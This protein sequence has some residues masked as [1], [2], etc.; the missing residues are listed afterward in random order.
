MKIKIITP[1]NIELEYSLANLGSR[2]AAFI[3]DS[4]IEGLIFSILLLILFCIYKIN[5]PF[6]KHF[7]VGS[8]GFYN[9]FFC[10]LSGVFYFFRNEYEWENHRKKAYENPYHQKKWTEFDL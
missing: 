9:C 5:E 3:I 8:G 10:N 4:I 2:A 1:E 6:G 7:T